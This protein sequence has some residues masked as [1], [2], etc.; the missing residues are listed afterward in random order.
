MNLKNIL[1]TG[2]LTS[3]LLGL[4]GC[5]G[6]GI[7]AGDFKT[8]SDKYSF[9]EVPLDDKSGV[10]LV[11]GDFDGDGNLDF[12]VCAKDP[13]NNRIVGKLYYFKGDGKGN[14]IKGSLKNK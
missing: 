14:F 7:A 13:Y 6:N 9:D 3:G 4:S 1:Y 10:A 8:E 11:A 12:I 2:I 5:A